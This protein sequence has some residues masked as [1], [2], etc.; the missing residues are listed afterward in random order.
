MG[1][2][3]FSALSLEELGEQNETAE[4]KQTPAEP[5]TDS[6]PTD[7]GVTAQAV[8]AEIVAGTPATP[9]DNTETAKAE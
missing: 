9:A 8:E 2:D 1:L 4:V 6:V 5:Q 7:E 3:K